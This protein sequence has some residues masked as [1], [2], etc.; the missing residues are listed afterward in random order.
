MVRSADY[1]T[2]RTDIFF[3]GFYSSR[4]PNILCKPAYAGYFP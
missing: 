2:N 3:F 4:E 1:E